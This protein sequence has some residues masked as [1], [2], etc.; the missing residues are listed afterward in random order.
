ML[1]G[2]IALSP[3]TTFRAELGF[4]HMPLATVPCVDPQNRAEIEPTHWRI[5]RI[6]SAVFDMIMFSIR[7]VLTYSHGIASGL[8][9]HFTL[10][11]NL[12]R[13]FTMIKRTVIQ[14]PP[15]CQVEDNGAWVQGADVEA[16]PNSGFVWSVERPQR[17]PRSTYLTE[18]WSF[19]IP[20]EDAPNE[21][22]AAF[23]N[24]QIARSPDVDVTLDVLVHHHGNER[25]PG[26]THAQASSR[27][28]PDM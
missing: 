25:E 17:D 7:S 14:G 23:V 19:Q 3:L 2:L 22:A 8:S 13:P 11:W 27:L 26:H 28:S 5:L 12:A 20:R 16:Q 15:I 10:S 4:E 1:R 21:R 18:A 9:W 24:V 6:M